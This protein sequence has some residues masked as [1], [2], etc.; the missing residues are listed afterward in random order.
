MKN[1]FTLLCFLSTAGLFSVDLDRGGVTFDFAKY[2]AERFAA[3]VPAAGNLITNADGKLA[4]KP[5]DVLRWRGSYCYVHSYALPDKDP[6][7]AQVR[8]MVKW[9]IK[10]GVFTVVKPAELKKILPAELLKSTSGGWFKSVDLPHDKGGICQVSFEYRSRIDGA[11]SLCLISSGYDQVAGKWAKAKRFSFKQKRLIPSGS[12]TRC[13]HEIPIPKGCKSLQ[14][15]FRMDG[16][17]EFEFRNPAAVMAEKSSV[18]NKVT[19]ALSPLGFLDK[20][21]VLAQK[22]PVT[23]CF[24]WKRNGTPAEA[25][26]K[27][28]VLVVQLPKEIEYHSSAQLKFLGKKKT[29]SGFEYRIDLNKVKQRP[30]RMDSF[31]SYLLHPLLIS[32]AAAPGT[33]IAGGKAWVEDMGKVISNVEIFSLKIIPP[34]QAE[35]PKLFATGFHTSGV[36][37]HF[38]GK[39]IERCAKLFGAAGTGWIISGDKNAY[40]AWRK[41]GVRII[42]PELYFIANGFRI[43]APQGRP[44][45]DK[46]RYVGDTYK[47]EMDRAVCP[48]AVYEKRPFFM[49][50]TVPYLKE[51]LKGA[52]GLWANWE[53]YLYRGR[54]CFCDT[55]RK[56]FAKFV[57]VPETE[58]AKAWPRA[59]AAGGKYNSEWVRFRSLEH[60]KLMN[61]LN[62]VVTSATGGKEKSLGF[63]PGIQVDDMSSTWREHKFDAENHPIDYAGN[64]KW[65][66]PWGPYS[67]W[68]AAVNPYIYSK[69]FSLRIFT[70]AREVRL[71]V[72]KDYPLPNRPK[73]LAFPHGHQGISRITHPES[74]KLDLLSYFFNGWEAATVYYF[75]RGYDARHWKAFAEATTTAAQYEEFVFKGKRV[76]GKITLTPIQPYA[77]DTVIVDHLLGR[78]NKFSMLQHTAYEKGNTLVA[79]VFNFWYHGEAF[80]NFKVKGLRSSQRYTVKCNGN[81]F[82]DAQGKSFT[83]RELA[84]GVMLHAGSVRCAVYEIAP[85]KAEDKNLPAVTPEALQKVYKSALPALRKAKAVD[86]E[87][88]KVNSVQESDL[89]DIANAGITCTADQK[90]GMLVFKSG[91]ISAEFHAPSCTVIKWENEK[92]K[93]ISGNRGSGAGAVAFWTPNARLFHTGYVVTRQEK[94]PGGIEITAERRVDAKSA[95]LL[96]G[97]TIV[98]K[99]RFTDGLKKISAS[100]VLT[101][102]TPR[103]LSFGVRYNMQVALQSATGGFAEIS[104]GGKPV[105]VVRDHSR[106]VYLSGTDKLFETTVRKLF[107]VVT[108][109]RLIDA[110]PV[111]FSSPAD[112]LILQ[113]EPRKEFVGAAVWDSGNQAAPT[114]EPCFKKVTLA[115][116]GGSVSY[117]AELRIVSKEKDTKNF[118]LIDVRTPEEFKAGAV[119]GAVNLP[120]DVIEQQISKAVPDK[121]QQIYVYCRSGRR[122]AAAAAK[123]KKAGYSSVENLGGFSEAGIKIKKIRNGKL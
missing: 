46:F 19:L 12:W 34:F 112:K 94:I 25:A 100:A 13:T 107:E 23:M 86:D 32:T 1:L 38:T 90:N 41:A 33:A 88:E 60:A 96:T 121:K 85:E 69:I 57:N 72:N 116:L 45:A 26:M 64:F 75:P 37:M 103:P 53:P 81:R 119:E 39:D 83:G 59:V 87:Y 43:G 115:P 91:N 48:A 35:R 65:I 67:H 18:A 105:K 99:L 80:F 78:V 118:V 74:L 97:L 54:G 51:E 3:A 21:F 31:D 9:S 84:A 123:L 14:L 114:F 11:G 58:L 95:P 109:T 42:T 110:A 122:S 68:D 50:K 66:D 24:T 30:A 71:A 20:T 108:P 113:V 82:V 111:S 61:V 106:Y 98:S 77:A 4:E 70:K 8:R 17:G 79:A 73:L 27:S 6:R 93:L 55:C 117:S 89:K 52:D 62:E 47:F 49:T 104:A 120:L 92:R 36:Y 63:V 40:A 2:S 76:D 22:L 15:V 28:P 10:D 16:V 5:S 101:N 102:K 44:E 29:A 56:K 7:R